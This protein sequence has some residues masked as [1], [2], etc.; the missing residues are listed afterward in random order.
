VRLLCLDTSTAVT[1]VALVEDGAVLGSSSTRQANAHGELLAPALAAL[2]AEHGTAYDGVACGTGPGPYTSLRVGIATAI[3]LAQSRGVPSWGACSLDLVGARS[4]GRTL[5]AQ[6]ARRREV[7]WARYTDGV[8]VDGPNVGAAADITGEYDSLLG[9]P[10]VMPGAQ[11]AQPQAQILW[12]LHLQSD[13]QVLL[14]CY[15]RE[16]DAVPTALRPPR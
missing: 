7:F 2:L 8:R 1:T 3:A 9:D 11:P 4:T 10:L 5:V 16:P 14:P 6:D 15:L 12:Q 13:P